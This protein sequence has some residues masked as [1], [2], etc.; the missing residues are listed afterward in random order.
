MSFP[1]L[2]PLLA[3]VAA[4]M[5]AASTSAYADSKPIRLMVGYAAGGPVDQTARILA[6]PLGEALGTTVV[7]ENKGGA[8]GTLAGTDVA[9][10]KPDGTTLWLA[11]SPTI[12]ISPNV[13]SKMRFDPATDLTPVAPVLSY[14]NVLMAHPDQPYKNVQELVDYA[15]QNPGKISY[16]SS[17]VGASNHLGVL[18]FA[19]KAGIDLNHI[20]YRGNAPAVTDLLGGQI[21]MMMDIVSTATPY[22]QSGQLRPIAIMAPQRNSSIPDVPTF[23]EAGLPDLEIGGWYGVYAPKGLPAEE[24]K[25]L[26]EAIRTVLEQPEVKKR[27]E[28]LGYE[29]WVGT[30][31]MLAERAAKDRAT[32]ATV[33]KDIQVD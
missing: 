9:R 27:L 12:T 20:P 4:V 2:R 29:N 26:N 25:R 13:M 30:P 18:L 14:Y 23:T 24:Q 1:K 15:R 28:D 19:E 11:A 32:W 22:L 3:T 6:T 21:N 8:G 5:V 33:T 7:V 16:G 10:A 17:G 31:E